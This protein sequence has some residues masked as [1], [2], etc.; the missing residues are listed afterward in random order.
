MEPVRE[1]VGN[2][3]KKLEDLEESALE[4]VGD[5]RAEARRLMRK[6]PVETLAVT[7]GA[8]LLVGLTFGIL[9]GSRYGRKTT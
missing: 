6:R 8:S 3:R 7:I 1:M 4:T 5:V 9:L 2:A